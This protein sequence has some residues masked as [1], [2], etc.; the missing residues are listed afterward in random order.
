MR[1]SV[2][3]GLGRTML[4]IPP[5]IWRRHVRAGAHLGFM[6]EDHHRVREFVVKELPRVAAPLSP[7]TIAER[8]NLPEERVT[9]LL[10]DLERHMTFL[11]RND[12]GFVTWAYP[13]T[14]EQT[15]HHMSFSTGER[16]DAA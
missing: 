2:L 13:V 12:R 8:L 3:L 14:A 7:G 11:F 16:I 4:P 15:P 5:A 1:K 10:D 9:R 6:S